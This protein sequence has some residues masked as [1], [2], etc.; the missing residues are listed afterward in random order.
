MKGNDQEKRRVENLKLSAKGIAA[1]TVAG[2]RASGYELQADYVLVDSSTKERTKARL[3]IRRW[4]A[5][6]RTLRQAWKEIVAFN[7]K[8]RGMDEDTY[9]L[10]TLGFGLVGVGSMNERQLK[11]IGHALRKMGGFPLAVET[12]FWMEKKPEEQQQETSG[13][14]GGGLESMMSSFIGGLV[15]KSMDPMKEK[16]GMAQVT[17]SSIELRKVKVGDVPDGYF[18]PPKPKRQQ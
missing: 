15:A 5:S 3:I 17:T 18:V 4:G 10:M 7:R 13:G 8:Y 14:G 9:Q 6:D 11:Q 1:R 2:H 16:N 12:E